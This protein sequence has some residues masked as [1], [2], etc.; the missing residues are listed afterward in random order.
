MQRRIEQAD[1]DRQPG[2]DP[3]DLGEVAALVG[4]QLGERGAAAGLVLGEDHLAHGGDPLGVEEHVLGAAQADAL[5]A[6]LARGA[7]VGGVSAL[8]RT[9]RR[10]LRV[11]PFHQR[12][13]IADQLGLDGR[14]LAEHHLAG[15]AVDGDRCRPRATSRPPTRISLRADSRSRARRRRETQGRPMPRATTAAWL[16]MP[17]R[18]VRMPLAACMP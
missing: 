16:V 7:A 6:E 12:A 5:G 3:E 10:R 11:G 8:V 2:H 9:F 15:R 17:P 13:E 4:Q 14:H 18:A 1:R